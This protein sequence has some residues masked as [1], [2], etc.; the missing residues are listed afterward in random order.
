MFFRKKILFVN[1]RSKSV[2]PKD[3]L[4]EFKK[5]T[6]GE[7]GRFAVEGEIW[8]AVRKLLI[9]AAALAAAYIIYECCMAWNIFQ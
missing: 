4:Y 7:M 1:K 8:R 2:K 9:L 6:R 3:P 5:S